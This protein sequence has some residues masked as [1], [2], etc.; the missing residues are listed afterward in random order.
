MDRD[1]G[2]GDEEEDEAVDKIVD[3]YDGCEDELESLG[4]IEEIEKPSEGAEEGAGR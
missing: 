1:G 3:E 2:E 4:V